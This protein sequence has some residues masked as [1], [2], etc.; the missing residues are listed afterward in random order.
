M[1][2]IPQWWY[3]AEAGEHR[4]P[5]QIIQSDIII[6][7]LDPNDPR[8]PQNRS[9]SWIL[10]SLLLCTWLNNIFIDGI[11]R[12]LVSYDLYHKSIIWIPVVCLHCVVR[13]H[14]MQRLQ[15]VSSMLA[16]HA[17]TFQPF[18]YRVHCRRVQHTLS[19]RSSHPLCS[20]WIIIARPFFPTLVL[21][22]L[23]PC[24]RFLW[25]V[26]LAF[27]QDQFRSIIS[28]MFPAH[29]V[30]FAGGWLSLHIIRIALHHDWSLW[31]VYRSRGGWEEGYAKHPLAQNHSLLAVTRG[32]SY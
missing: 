11:K 2:I 4:L 3:L 15:S 19:P 7:R 22:T 27:V 24:V 17:F 16:V 14:L 9:S 26:P 23:L 31:C 6:V 20:V 28:N 25:F 12:Q 8:P 13:C 30:I 21:I 29:V 18:A 1:T 5:Q 10:L 32:F